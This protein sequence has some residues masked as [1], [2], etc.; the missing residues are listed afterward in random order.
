[1]VH[2]EAGH[3]GGAHWRVAHFPGHGHQ[4]VT[5]FGVGAQAVDNLDHLHQGHGVEEMEA[6]HAAGTPARLGNGR[7]GQRRRI[8]RQNAVV[9]N[10]GFKLLEQPALY[11]QAFD[12]RLDHQNGGAHCLQVGTCLNT[13]QGLGGRIGA[14]SFLGDQACPNPLEVGAR[15]GNRVRAHVIQQDVHAGLSRNLRNAAPHGARANYPYC[16]NRTHCINS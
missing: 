4:G 11:L 14:H 10:N 8:G 9:G 5:R 3:I 1:M 15:C 2:Y 7:D 12:H 6:G 13:C 16:S